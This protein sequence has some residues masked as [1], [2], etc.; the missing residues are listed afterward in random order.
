[1]TEK[2]NRILHMIMT[3]I[4]LVSMFFIAREGAAEFRVIQE[5]REASNMQAGEKKICVVIDAGHGGC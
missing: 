3:G 2:R 1:M 4:L 5:G